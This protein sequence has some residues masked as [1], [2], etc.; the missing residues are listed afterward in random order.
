MGR[1]KTKVVGSNRKR[2]P[3]EVLVHYVLLFTNTT[4]KAPGTCSWTHPSM[5]SMLDDLIYLTSDKAFLNCL[6][7]A[8]GS[9]RSPE[10]S[11]N[12]VLDFP[13]C[14]IC[15]LCIRSSVLSTSAVLLAEE[16]RP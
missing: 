5:I 13:L 11:V 16:F 2:E 9:L 12:K 4:A 3:T 6:E 1:K 8:V 14:F 10:S 7:F 15:I